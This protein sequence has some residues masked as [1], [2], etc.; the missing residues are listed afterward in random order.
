MTKADFLATL[1]K[2]L[3]GTATESE[4]KLVDDFYRHHLAQSEREWTFTDKERIRIEILESLNRAI[5]EEEGL[6]RTHPRRMWWVAAS[7]ALL[8]AASV[9]LYLMRIAPREIHYVTSTAQRGEQITVTLPDSSV[10]RLNA[11]SSI[12]YPENFEDSENRN[13]QLVG[14]AFFEVTRDESKPFIIQS[15]DL[16]TTVLGTTFN[17]RGYPEEESIAVTVA[18]GKVSVEVVSDQDQKTATEF[19]VTGEQGLYQKGSANITKTNVNLEKYLAWKDG[20]IL[21]ESA[22]LEE[23]TGILGRWYNAEF[24]FKNPALKT[25]TIDGKFRNDQLPNILENLRFLLG[26]EYRIEEGNRIIIDGKSCQH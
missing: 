25:C 8:I 14:E 5:D 3:N 22:S 2:V 21:L 6:H 15:G 12:T 23:A 1:D 18:T 7:V 13:V 9:G 24:V 4:R 10:V 26:I 20:T 16:I 17:I 11:E 19:L